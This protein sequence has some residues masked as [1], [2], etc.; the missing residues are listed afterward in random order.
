MTRKV[1]PIPAALAVVDR[2]LQRAQRAMHSADNQATTLLKAWM[3]E[4]PGLDTARVFPNA[5]GGPLSGD[6]VRYILE[7]HVAVAATDCPSLRR[8]N[9]TPHVL[10]HYLPFPTM[11]GEARASGIWIRTFQI[12]RRR[13]LD[14][15][16]HNFALTT[17]CSGRLGVGRRVYSESVSP[18]A[19]RPS[20]VLSPS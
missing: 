11:S 12:A 5:R 18:S 20:P 19:E 4:L 9:V 13:A 16:R 10:R 2:V 3:R 1:S 15:T 7:K 17:D 8:K 14:I 6:G